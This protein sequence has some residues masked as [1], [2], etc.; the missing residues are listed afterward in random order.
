MNYGREKGNS[1][2]NI[3]N[4]VYNPAILNNKDDG[5]IRYFLNGFQPDNSHL[6]SLNASKTL[7]K[8][9]ATVYATTPSWVTINQPTFTTVASIAYG[10][11]IWVAVGAGSNTLGTWNTQTSQFGASAIAS[12]WQHGFGGGLHSRR[13]RPASAPLAQTNA[14]D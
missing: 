11:G 7:T 13:E 14:L 1:K 5:V 12:G 10:N 4:G 2:D 8:V 9:P 3:T 6:T